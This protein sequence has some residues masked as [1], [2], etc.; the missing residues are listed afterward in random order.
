MSA[1]VSDRILLRDFACKKMGLDRARRIDLGHQAGSR[2]TEHGDASNTKL[3][4][5]TRLCPLGSC[6]LVSVRLNELPL[7]YPLLRPLFDHFQ[8][9]T[10]Q[11][12]SSQTLP[13]KAC[14]VKDHE[15]S[16][17]D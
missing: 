1:V 10:V 14:K 15:Y 17:H 9:G 11:L 16:G 2:K 6:F 8:K 12:H 4:S 7:P 13:R 5:C 3:K